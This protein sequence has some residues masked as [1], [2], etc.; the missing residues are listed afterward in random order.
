MLFQEGLGFFCQWGWFVGGQLF[1]FWGSFLFWMFLWMRVKRVLG[2]FMIRNVY[3]AV[4]FYCRLDFVV[5]F[6]YIMWVDFGFWR[7]YGKSGCFIFCFF[8][9]LYGLIRLDI[10]VYFW[11]GIGSESCSFLGLVR[12]CSGVGGVV[13]SRC[14]YT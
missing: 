8:S 6:G 9:F 4:G 3:C 5:F 2:G 7:I 11:N 12:F 14:E 1:V 13:V 10:N